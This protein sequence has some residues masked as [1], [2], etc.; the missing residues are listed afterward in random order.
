MH[1]ASTAAC[2]PNEIYTEIVYHLH[3]RR[4]RHLLRS[5]ALVS[6][7]LRHASQRKLFSNVDGEGHDIWRIDERVVKTHTLFLQ[8]VIDRPHRLGS[9]VLSY[10]QD[11]LARDPKSMLPVPRI[12]KGGIT[13]QD[14]RYKGPG[15]LGRPLGS[16]GSL[17]ETRSRKWSI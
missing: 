9:Y 15:R 2:L 3:Y 14:S 1:S 6:Q 11:K 10:T 7:A 4:D 13:I 17:Q 12:K 16:Y 8:A 5:L